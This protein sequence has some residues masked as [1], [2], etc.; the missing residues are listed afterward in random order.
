MALPKIVAPTFSLI[1]PS[2]KRE[3]IFR[4]FLVKEEK[5]L[6]IAMESKDADHM[7]RAMLEVLS[8][9]IVT[10]GVDIE[11]LPSFD[12]EYLFLKIRAKSVGENVN[13]SYRHVDGVNYKGEPCETV[14]KVEIN[15][16]DVEVEFAEDHSP[17]IKLTDKL[18]MKMRYPTLA[19]IKSSVSA[20]IDEI[21]LI[22]KCIE[23]V[24]DDE[25]M[26]EPDS[27]D[28]ARAFI[29]SLSNSQFI[30]IMKF[31]E[32]MPRLQHTITYKCEGCGQ[33]DTI[34]LK[35]LSDFF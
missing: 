19:D 20:E 23:C 18:V 17:L 15:L 30:E 9:C 31:F 8:N 7:N 21:D 33:E 34:T 35:G 12:I 26:F 22:T 27:L 28:E 32:T 1:L 24:Y 4:P 25:E 13:L 29:G 11:K 16:D 5:S 10:E 3:I 2:D 6:L 14:T